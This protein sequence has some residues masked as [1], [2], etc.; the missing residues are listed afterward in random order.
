MGTFSRLLAITTTTTLFVPY[1]NLHD[2]KYYKIWREY[3]L[4]IITIEG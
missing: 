1:I 3:R 4:T 2:T